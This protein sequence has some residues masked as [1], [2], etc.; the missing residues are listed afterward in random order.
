MADFY[1]AVTTDAGLALSA[2]LLTGE[3]MVFTKLVTGSGEYAEGELT[4]SRL[5][6]AWQIKEPRDR[7]SVV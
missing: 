7:K 1:E 2:D 4:R 6:K 3:Q 5:Q